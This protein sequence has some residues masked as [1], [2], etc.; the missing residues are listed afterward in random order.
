MA[1]KKIAILGGG[2]AGLS[3]AYQLTRTTGL[4]AQHEVT[5]YQLGWRVG[6]KAASG[7]DPWDRN[8]EHG[9]HVWFGCYYNMFQMTQ[10]VYGLWKKPDGCPLQ[11]WED[12]AK[13][14]VYT[15][16]GVE[17]P[18]GWTYFPLTW[19]TNEG[20][21]G[22]DGL[23]M[24]LKEALTTL[25]NFIKIAL[26]NIIPP[27][28]IAAAVRHYP[29]PEH[30][31]TVATASPS[32]RSDETAQAGALYAQSRVAVL[33]LAEKLDALVLWTKALEQHPAARDPAHV[34][35]LV[36]LYAEIEA[37]HHGV[38]AT[39]PEALMSPA[40]PPGVKWQ[41]MGEL[42]NLFGAMFRGYLN[43]LI[44]PDQPFES[45]DRLDFRA[46]L[47]ENGAKPEVVGDSSIVHALYDTMFQY[48]DG[49]VDRPSYAAGSAL[50]VLTRM[51]ATFKGSVMWNIQA[52]MGEAVV[53]PIYDVLR[54]NGV[55]FR[56]FR[57]V[58]KLEVSGGAVS[59]IQL[60]VQAQVKESDYVPT[61]LHPGLKLWCW[62][63]QPLWEQLVD[64]DKL[65]AAG[66]NFES[67]WS[68]V[69]NPGA[70]TLQAGV[71]YDQVVLA[72]AMGA[73]KPLNAEPSMC[74]DLIAA[75]TGFANFVNKM[76]LVPSQGLQLWSGWTNEAL[77]WT[78]GQ[79]AMVSGPQYLNI[80]DDMSQVLRF[81]TSPD[82]PKTLRYITGTF[83]T[84]LHKE[85][86]TST[87]T[88]AK[89]LAA[90]RAGT[91]AWLES[92]SYVMWPNACDGKSFRYEVLSDPKNGSGLQRLDSQYL[93]PNIDPTECC[94][95]STAGSTQYRLG[96]GQS[97]FANLILAGEA[98]RH[99]FNTTTIE[100]AVMSGMAASRAIC[101]QPA[102]I[103]GYDF[104]RTPPSQRV[105]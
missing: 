22:Q 104:L 45:L 46:W 57:K 47:L 7:R 61:Y 91:I 39:V 20:I 94:V 90:M 92:S 84:Q 16:L 98:T 41:I 73:Y 30:F 52:G 75:N 105:Q 96:P 27:P 95:A 55:K 81:E 51:I 14:Q 26:Q 49:D 50:G 2:M 53:A 1:K 29:L 12:V 82:Q 28:A 66:V 17:Q 101:G 99:G 9:L 8:L 80:W 21:P 65:Q 48:I 6:G 77:G 56:F 15:P 102:V 89:A 59:R 23:D 74:A 43:D 33:S 42:L 63:S 70:E 18:G 60:E 24:T 100:G 4:Q 88:P 5:V 71:D 76:D 93:R 38:A 35:A 67:H 10:E 13:Y 62:P 83:K 86:S 97:G 72:I 68:P 79:A 58:T 87:G 64:G 40:S 85:P 36:D 32:L 11:G 3:A 19:P 25:V 78:T 34:A 69:P 44:V 31:L 37:S 54:A 103:V